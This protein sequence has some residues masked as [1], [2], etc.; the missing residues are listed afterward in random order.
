MIT[1]S[2][3]AQHH[4]RSLLSK[5]PDGTQIRVFITN[6]GTPMAECGVAYCSID[7]VEKSDIRFEYNQ[8]SI[9]INKDLISFLK[10]AE[11]DLIVDKISSQ[12]TLKA[13]YAKS[14][15]FQKK[16]SSLEDKIKYFLNVEINPQLLMHGG[17]VNLIE[18]DQK[19]G[20]AIIQFRGG[21][22]GCSMIGITL[23]ETVEKKLLAAFPE[24]KKV[25]DGT[26]HLHGQHS[27]Y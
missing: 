26:E 22:N 4:F 14:N 5:E 9:Y 7:E 2:E 27:F 12:L 16:Y 1:I 15:I 3:S 6:P 8:F 21:C 24:I 11:I 19:N 25:Y 23:K 20:T 10:N 18:I 17:E 13:P